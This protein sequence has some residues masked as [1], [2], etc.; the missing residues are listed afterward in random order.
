MV[1]IEAFKGQ[2]HPHLPTILFDFL[3]LNLSYMIVGRCYIKWII[4]L[5]DQGWKIEN[6][7]E[8]F[9]CENKKT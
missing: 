7:D 1:V 6:G 5:V 2:K 4:K 8:E 3:S 9:F